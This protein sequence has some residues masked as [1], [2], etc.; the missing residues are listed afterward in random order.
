MH[1]KVRASW[2]DMNENSVDQAHFKF[3]HGTLTIPPTK[4]R[5]EGSVHVTES[6]FTMRVPG[7][8]GETTLTTLDH[9]PGFQVVRMTGLIDTLMM[10]TSTPID[11]ENT[12]VSF[13]YSVR[14]EGDSREAEDWPS[15][16]SRISSSNS[17]MIGPS[18]RTRSVGQSL[19]SAKGMAPSL[20]I[21]SGIANSFDSLFL[22]MRG[23]CCTR[24]VLSSE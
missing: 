14:H 10:N 15:L 18:G 3:V 24:A 22:L 5:V 9:G 16:L 8:E 11:E 6:V 21:E 13:S 7:G 19:C 20:T 1:W 23:Q 12:D 4:A 2:L 17:S